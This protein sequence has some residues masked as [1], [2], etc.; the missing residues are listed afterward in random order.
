MRLMLILMCSSI[1]QV[2]GVLLLTW[3]WQNT[4]SQLSC[5]L[6]KPLLAFPA[7]VPKAVNWLQQSFLVVSERV[8]VEDRVFSLLL[9]WPWISH[10]ESVL[11]FLGI[12]VIENRFRAGNLLLEGIEHDVLLLFLGPWIAGVESVFPN[13][14]VH[15]LEDW[16]CHWSKRELPKCCYVP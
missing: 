6:P 11:V 4:E 12:P 16:R 7:C 15:I 13:L 14:Y 1:S 9:T 5:I 2:E 10:V 3:Q 8:R